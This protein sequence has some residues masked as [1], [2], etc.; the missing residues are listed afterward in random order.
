[1]FGQNREQLRQFYLQVWQKRRDNID[2]SG[3]EALVAQ[4]IEAHPEYQ[5]LLESDQALHR[6]FSIDDGQTNPFL[7]MGM[8]ITLAEQLASDRPAGIRSL[9]PRITL[10][11]G[12]AHQAAHKMMDCLGLI[13]WEAQRAG[14][15]PDEQAFLTCMQ[16]LAAN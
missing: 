10:K 13:L 14:R 12:H 9:H 2:L 1:M 8:H 16:K 15:A 4:V 11:T 3:L 7:H 5:A 6:D